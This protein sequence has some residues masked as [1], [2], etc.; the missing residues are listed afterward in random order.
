M[1]PAPAPSDSNRAGLAST[2]A[3]AAPPTSID[4]VLAP[5]LQWDFICGEEYGRENDMRD[6][7][8]ILY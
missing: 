7:S 8:I 1:S 5:L 3:T 2:T 6:P 4:L